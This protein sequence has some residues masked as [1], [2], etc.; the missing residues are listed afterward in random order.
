[1]PTASCVDMASAFWRSKWQRFV[2]VGAVLVF[3]SLMLGGPSVSANTVYFPYKAGS[4][5]VVVGPSSS[6]CGSSQV[7]GPLPTFSLATGVAQGEIL[8]SSDTNGTCGGMVITH[9]NSLEIG[10]NSTIQCSVT[11]CTSASVNWTGN[12]TLTDYAGGPICATGSSFGITNQVNEDIYIFNS[13]GTQ[14]LST[15]KV[16]LDFP[17]SSFTSPC[18][19]TIQKTI[20][21]Q[22]LVFGGL[23]LP[24][25]YYY[26]ESYLDSNIEVNAGGKVGGGVYATATS[27][28]PVRS[29]EILYFMSLT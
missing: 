11:V 27:D 21:T 22:K 1:M 18:G 14:V 28:F 19:G 16:L 15:V 3:A 6:N 24:I 2:T 5:G 20:T 25:G 17:Y 12:F 7:V 13:T 8:A 23:N 9:I 26:I 29:G 4:P 10:L